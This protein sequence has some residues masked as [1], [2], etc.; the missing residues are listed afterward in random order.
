MTLIFEPQKIELIDETIPTIT[1]SS[2]T[3]DYRY[4]KSP[5]NRSIEELLNYGIINLD[6]PPNP[7]SHEVVSF[8]KK[9]L[10]IPRAG[11][12]GTLDPAVTGVLPI[13]LNK[14]TRI[15][16]TL[17]LA[18]KEYVSVMQV[19]QDIP[20]DKIKEVMLE[21]VG[22]IFQRPPI[23]A[24]VK[25][26][27]RKRKIYELK[28]LEIDDRLVLFKMS[29]QAGTYVR[30]LCLHPTT[31]ILTKNGSISIT[32]FYKNP[33]IVLTF[34]D[35]KVVEK[36][37]SAVQ[38]IKAPS[39][40]IKITMESGIS[41][42]ATPDHEM[43]KSTLD[44]YVMTEVKDLKKGDYLVKS[45]NYHLP[46][47]KLIIADLLDD[48]F[49]IDQQELKE[50]CKEAFIQKYGSI[51]AMSEALRID[52]KVFYSDSRIAI[53]IKHLKLA[54][55]YDKVK[56]NIHRFKFTKG[57]TV[58]L[59]NLNDEFFYL[60][61]LIA[62][63]GNNTKE[64]GTVRY[65]RIMFHNKEK[66]LI[67]KFIEIYERLFPNV[68]YTVKKH[69]HEIWGVITSNSLMASIAASLGIKSP[70]KHS[71]FSPLLYIE[72]I[73][74]KAYLKGY[75][76]GDGSAYYKKYPN[77]IKTRISLFT[78]SEKEAVVLHKI[79]L[80]L[81]IENR[82]FSRT[83][84]KKGKVEVYYEVSIGIIGAQHKFIKEIGSNH[85]N[86]MRILEKI[87]SIEQEHEYGNNYHVGLHF[88]KML[89]ENKTELKR[90]MG[91]NLSRLLGKN[92]P[93]TRRFYK[94]ASSFVNLPSLDDFII[95]KI[96]KI[97]TVDSCD[98]V[99]DMTVPNTHNFLIETGY[100]SSNCH[101]IGQSL[102]CGAHM[103]ELRRIRTG[104]FTEETFLSTLHDLYD[105]FMWYKEEKDEIPLRNIILPMEFAVKHLPKIYVK[106]NAVDTI[107]HGAPVALP[108]I[109]KITTNFK[110]GD[111]VA[112]HTL[113]NE[114]VALGDAQIDA[115]KLEKMDSGLIVKTKRVLMPTGTYPKSN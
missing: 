107:C 108:A 28:I 21:Y 60:L 59:K 49:L 110:E 101:D 86:K 6:K 102:G 58:D 62:S 11:H 90:I 43:L 104:P 26:V 47:K 15:L 87:R 35:G 22:E 18:G 36:T 41:F 72:P 56:K 114:L 3:T 91:G 84:T 80:K 12:S 37:P 50:K 23:R 98:Y 13:A 45:L 73:L 4:G 81:S 105:A 9:I 34:N 94:R 55:I 10:E 63:D 46:N 44:G 57:R 70:K 32:D 39:Q 53:K 99:Y 48:E 33:T 40:L 74:L 82:I 19:H 65:T 7:T 88:N 92:I 69:E 1:L 89:S 97:E 76:D 109:S 51:R 79:L 67:D 25:R 61:G 2:E 77:H 106:D 66:A 16:D 68:H 17:L 93:V 75:F 64:K 100:V 113:K 78:F 96:E 112:I 85:P 29:C 31:Q 14:A 115:T 8:V 27:L 5:L 20:H 95:E 103:K 111:T 24:S 30:K 83:R 52:R 38:K 54:G 42:I 71:D